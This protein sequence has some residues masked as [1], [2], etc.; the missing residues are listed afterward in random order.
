LSGLLA[1]CGSQVQ[2][3]WVRLVKKDDGGDSAR[4]K[5]VLLSWLGEK[6]P[7]LAKGRASEHKAALAA[8]QVRLLLRLRRSRRPH[9]THVRAT[10]RCARCQ[11]A[12][13]RDTPTVARAERR[14]RL[15]PSLSQPVAPL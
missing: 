15:A 12:A 8:L 14:G 9:T 13:L 4:V 2:F 5:F 10:R 1:L 11:G 6:A 3:A 7:P